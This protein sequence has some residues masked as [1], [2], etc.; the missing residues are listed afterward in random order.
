MGTWLWMVRIDRPLA[1]EEARAL[2]SLLPPARQARLHREPPEKHPAVLGAY[3][4]LAALLRER[5]GWTALPAMERSAGGR[6]FFPEYPQVYFSLSHTEGAA[7]AAVSE[8]PVGADIQR[9]RPD[10]SP[11]LARLTGTENP[12]IFYRDWACREAR[13]KQRG[14]GVLSLL[15]QAPD[16]LPGEACA[17]LPAFPG[18]AAGLAWEGTAPPEP[19]QLLTAEELLHC[20]DI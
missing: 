17:E 8:A 12:A 11:R 14:T 16:A 9:I 18:Y 5:R 10:V 15:R 4:L 7:A 13:A 2:T 6:P 1:E 20:L 19:P 3:G